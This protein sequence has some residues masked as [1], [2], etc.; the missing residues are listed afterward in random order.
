MIMGKNFSFS[1]R[2]RPYKISLKQS[3]RQNG[4]GLSAYR[5]QCLAGAK[6]AVLTWAPSRLLWHLVHVTIAKRKTV[7]SLEPL[8]NV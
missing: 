3:V 2:S 1:L 6:W 4:M 8:V 7:F 5:L